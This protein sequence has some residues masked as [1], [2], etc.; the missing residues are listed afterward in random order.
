LRRNFIE[1]DDLRHIVLSLGTKKLSSLIPFLVSIK[2]SIVDAVK[3]LENLRGASSTPSKLPYAQQIVALRRLCWLRALLKKQ[4]E[5]IQKSGATTPETIAVIVENLEH[6]DWDGWGTLWDVLVNNPNLTDKRGLKILQS[7]QEEMMEEVL[8]SIKVA[9]PYP[10]DEATWC[11]VA[12]RLLKDLCIAVV[13]KSLSKA[14]ETGEQRLL[15]Y[16]KARS[17]VA[18]NEIL[19]HTTVDD[20][21]F[22]ASGVWKRYSIENRIIVKKEQPGAKCILINKRAS[23]SMPEPFILTPFGSLDEVEVHK[24]WYLVRQVIVVLDA[25]TPFCPSA[26]E[27]HKVTLQLINELGISE[28]TYRVFGFSIAIGA[29][30]KVYLGKSKIT[31]DEIKKSQDGWLLEMDDSWPA[32]EETEDDDDVETNLDAILSFGDNGRA[33]DSIIFSSLLRPAELSKENRGQMRTKNCNSSTKE[34]PKT[35]Q[36]GYCELPPGLTLNEH[37]P[38]IEPLDGGWPDGWS[39]IVCQRKNGASAGQ[40]DRY[41]FSPKEKIKLRSMVEVSKFI[42]LLSQCGGNE[43]EAKRCLK[44]ATKPNNDAT[45]SRKKK[46]K[47]CSPTSN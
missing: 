24:L 22:E 10:F 32:N 4:F 21:A 14:D 40:L 12:Q 7:F 39:R 17:H 43:I 29:E 13:E 3:S 6:L 19:N 15:D 26:D 18:A 28:S 42:A 38:P 44:N 23:S 45:E 30:D 9:L 8:Y 47:K 33:N 25:F 31:S 11:N 16:F 35:Q 1:R 37:H 27:S 46:Q 5:R 36:R 20:L 34:K 41:W 2:T